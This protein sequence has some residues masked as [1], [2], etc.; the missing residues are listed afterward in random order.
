M[1]VKW[2]AAGAILAALAPASGKA[3]VTYTFFDASTPSQVDVSFSVATQ[4][5]TNG[6]TET[7]AHISGVESSLFVGKSADYV[8]GPPDYVPDIV[9]VAELT[10]FSARF[11]S[12]PSGN[13]ANGAPGNGSFAVDGAILDAG[14]LVADLGS[15]TIAGVPVPEPCS[16]AV[17]SVAALGC[18]VR[19]RRR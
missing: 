19:R 10:N 18:A 9:T 12:F 17:L 13:P 8:Q 16:L 5:A 7:M 2:L 14:I 4:L 3:S 1:I 15:A 6:Q 11:S